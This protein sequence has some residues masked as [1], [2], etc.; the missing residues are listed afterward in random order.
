MSSTKTSIV[1][2]TPSSSTSRSSNRTPSSSAS[3]TPYETA[4]VTASTSQ[5]ATGTPSSTKSMTA[6]ETAA[7]T[8]SAFI[9]PEGSR[10]FNKIAPAL[11]HHGWSWPFCP[12]CMLDRIVYSVQ[13]KWKQTI[14]WHVRYDGTL[15]DQ[16]AIYFGIKNNGSH[17][18]NNS[19]QDEDELSSIQDEA[20]TLKRKILSPK[21]KLN[22]I[23]MSRLQML[24][25]S[26]KQPRIL[27][28]R[29]KRP[30]NFFLKWLK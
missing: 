24:D 9:D 17:S 4:S 15:E 7:A 8:P 5:S 3:K 12:F 16:Y 26:R 29:P 20:Y 10:N 2:P 25:R 13:T 23:Q 1:S 14:T 11:R 27:V 18:E 19:S 6:S 21:Q 28:C 22:F 30:I